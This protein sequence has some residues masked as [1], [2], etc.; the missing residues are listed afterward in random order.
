MKKAFKDTI[1]VMAGYIVLGIGFGIIL[2]SSGYGVLWAFAMSLF[3]YAGSMQYL[4]IGL[5]TGG[6]SFLTVAITTLMVNARHLFYG[7]SMIDRYKKMGPSKPY[8]IFALTDETYSLVCSGHEEMSEQERRKYFLLVSLFDQT[9]WVTGSVIG[10][11]IGTLITF[12]TEGID[13]ALTALFITVFTDQWLKTKKHLPAIIGVL[14][15]VICL[16]IFKADN[17]LIPSMIMITLLLAVMKKV[18][19]DGYDHDEEENKEVSHE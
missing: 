11:L 2:Q 12:N 16:L 13:F 8:L 1:P 18:K 3:I 9:Y 17:F 6:A 5:I 19:P 4:G 10:S 15:S 14:A 7:I